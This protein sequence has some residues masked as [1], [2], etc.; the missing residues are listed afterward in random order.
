MK[1][2][3]CGPY[4]VVEP[5]GVTI[6]CQKCDWRPPGSTR[7][8]ML[9]PDDL[10][11]LDTAVMVCGTPKSWCDVKFVIDYSGSIPKVTNGTRDPEKATC[12]EC[13]RR[14]QEALDLDCG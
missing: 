11:H 12:E 13:L 1:C 9:K 10:V 5:D 4:M 8:E 3:K 14:Y 7:S 6:W 2:P